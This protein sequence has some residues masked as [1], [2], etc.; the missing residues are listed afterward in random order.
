M[1]EV[2]AFAAPHGVVAVSARLL[3][4]VV[5]LGVAAVLILRYRGGAPSGARPT[6]EMAAH[7]RLR[8]RHQG[9]RHGLM[10]R[11]EGVV[12]R[13]RCRCGATWTRVEQGGLEAG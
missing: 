7:A 9:R 8:K 10:V 3:I 4:S 11:H 1:V 12:I 2:V 5:A 13:Y 6:P